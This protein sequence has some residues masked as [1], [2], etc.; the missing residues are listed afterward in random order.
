MFLE[1]SSL[2]HL[3]H[4]PGDAPGAPAGGMTRFASSF[5]LW[6]LLVAFRPEGRYAGVLSTC[7]LAFSHVA[8]SVKS[9]VVSQSIAGS[10]SICDSHSRTVALR[11]WVVLH[12]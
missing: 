11:F 9:A 3:R 12:K 8:G 6:G 10:S 5:L 7:N 1:P 4:L 2:G